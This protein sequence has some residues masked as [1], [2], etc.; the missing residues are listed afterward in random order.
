MVR[1]LSAATTKDE[2]LFV[3]E[4]EDLGVNVYTCTDDGSCGFKG[5]ATDRVN[6]L[7]KIIIIFCNM[8]GQK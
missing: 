4:L 2:L 6:D 7:L 3:E 1:L 5:F 8:Y